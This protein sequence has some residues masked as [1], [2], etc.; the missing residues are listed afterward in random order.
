MAQYFRMKTDESVRVRHILIKI[1]P[2]ASIQERSEA[3]RK[4]Q[5]IRKK[6]SGGED[7]EDAARKYSQDPGS[8]PKGGD[9]GFIVKGQM[10][11]TFERAAFALPVGG[12][13][14]VVQTE[15]GYHIIK[16]EEKK[17]PS[18]LR[19]EDVKDDLKE[20]L[21]RSAAR[22]QYNQFVDGL[23]KK[24]VVDLKADFTKPS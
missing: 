19:L 22:E 12:V 10:V 23:R 16:V 17:A 8:A 13:S 1:D 9:L 7:F 5:D 20:Y 18:K 2:N 4:A 6:I 15:F 11:K 21:F 24:A 3:L 14:D